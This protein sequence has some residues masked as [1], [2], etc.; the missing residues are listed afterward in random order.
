MVTYSTPYPHARKT[1]GKPLITPALDV[2]VNRKF[3]T[4]YLAERITSNYD[5]LRQLR[6]RLGKKV[7]RAVANGKLQSNNGKYQFGHFAA[8][9]RTRK[10]FAAAVADIA[11]T[12]TGSATAVLPGMFGQASGYSLPNTL[13]DCKAALVVAY[14]ELNQLRSENQFLREVVAELTPYKQKAIARSLASSIAGKKG[15]RSPQR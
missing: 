5:T 14:R 2:M 9:A 6:D 1:I 3:V 12:N 10:D 7:D 8:W 13:E 11:V 4:K 15:K